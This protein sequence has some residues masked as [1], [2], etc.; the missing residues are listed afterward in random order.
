MNSRRIVLHV[1]MS[2]SLQWYQISNIYKTYVYIQ[3]A[4]LLY[5]LKTNNDT[6]LHPHRVGSACHRSV[7]RRG[8][9]ALFRFPYDVVQFS[10]KIFVKLSS[11]PKE[12]IKLHKQSEVINNHSSS[13][14]FVWGKIFSIQDRI[15][16][17]END[18]DSDQTI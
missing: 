9:Q 1:S 3:L 18:N 7:Q 2:S 5:S 13:S 14:S 16:R 8:W 4:C 6:L 17:D 11:T 10:T 15:L 12:F